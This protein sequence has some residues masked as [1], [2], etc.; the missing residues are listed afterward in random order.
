MVFEHRL[1]ARRARAAFEAG[2]RLPLVHEHERR[3]EGY[4]KLRREIGSALE[5]DLRKAEAMA[6]LARDVGE[7]ALHAA[8]RPR[9]GRCEEEQEWAAVGH[10]AKDFAAQCPFSGRPKPRRYTPAAMG[11]WYWI[12][13]FAGIGAALGLAAAAAFPR[14]LVAAVPAAALGA[15]VGY[16]AVNWPEAVGGAVGG[17]AGALGAAPVVAGAVRRG[18]TRA[19]LAVFVAI[20]AAVVAALAFVPALGYVEVLVLPAFGLRL[21][22]RLPERYAGLRTLAR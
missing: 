8:R 10:R 15:A 3:R 22:S 2:D 1:D 17:L 6:L 14:W 11:A 4:G 5:V 12:G 20:G 9:M 19:G 18:G 16:L 21:R 13:V 7:Q